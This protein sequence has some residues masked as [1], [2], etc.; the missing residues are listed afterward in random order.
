MR[1]CV[2]YLT[3]VL[4]EKLQDVQI[5]V[6]DSDG[7]SVSAQ[8]VYAVDVEFAVSVL[9]QELLHHVVVPWRANQRQCGTPYFEN[10]AK[11]CL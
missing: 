2:Y 9:L 6:F 10:L 11:F 3:A 5:L 7:H 4:Q 1:V 8:H